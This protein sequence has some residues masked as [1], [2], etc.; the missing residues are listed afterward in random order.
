MG[1]EDT[2]F[3]QFHD[4]ANFLEM[5]SILQDPYQIS[6]LATLLSAETIDYYKVGKNALTRL[7]IKFEWISKLTTTMFDEQKIMKCDFHSK[8]SPILR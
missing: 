2:M 8:F 7:T 6:N 5:Y 1:Q 4:E 3:C